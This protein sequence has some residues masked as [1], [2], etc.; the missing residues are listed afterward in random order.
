VPKNRLILAAMLSGMLTAAA[1]AAPV[2]IAIDLD[3]RFLLG[4]G[5]D[6]SEVATQP[7]FQSWDLAEEYYPG[8]A[9]LNAND[10]TFTLVD[11]ADPF[12]IGFG[13]SIGARL[14]TS[15][16]GGGPLD[17]LLRDFV[18][19]NSATPPSSGPGGT[20]YSGLLLIVA[21]LAPGEYRMTSWHFDSL[22]RDYDNRIRIAIGN[23][24]ETR[25]VVE[26]SFP[27]GATPATYT[28]EVTESG[29]T[30]H[31][32]YLITGAINPVVQIPDYNIRLNG[33]TLVSVPEPS[34]VATLIMCV[35]V[36]AGGCRGL[37]AKPPSS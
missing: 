15:E 5:P 36:M 2:D 22:I 29:Q 26:E 33:F 23:A 37:R 34:T 35:V 12:G 9:T 25:E 17:A 6:P 21:G 18:W 24:G 28:F 8:G 14:R 31:I 19:L 1:L 30:K 7:G 10:V 4:N 3:T 20:R 16:E 13:S 27:L 32:Y 11:W